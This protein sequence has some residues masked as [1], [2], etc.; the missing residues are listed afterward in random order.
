MGVMIVRGKSFIYI[1]RISLWIEIG[2]LVNG[3]QYIIRIVINYLY[4]SDNVVSVPKCALPKNLTRR[5]KTKVINITNLK[6]F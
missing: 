5:G 6:F 2:N 1:I 3:K 4:L